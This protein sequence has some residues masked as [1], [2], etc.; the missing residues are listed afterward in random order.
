MVAAFTMDSPDC[1]PFQAEHSQ[2]QRS[3]SADGQL[4]TFDGALQDTD[5]M[6]QGEDFELKPVR[7]RNDAMANTMA[8]MKT[9]PKRK[10]AMSDN[11]QFISRIAVYD[12]HNSKKFAPDLSR[13]PPRGD[14]GE[15]H[16][17]C[18]DYGDE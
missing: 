15:S 11:F 9:A 13:G 8:A 18:S 1:Q 5:L 12:N 7:L 10:P 17:R 16:E 14:C 4:R 3:L 2:A 6:A